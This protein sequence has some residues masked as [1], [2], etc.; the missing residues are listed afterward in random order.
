MAA[1]EQHCVEPDQ[2]ETLRI[3]NPPIRAEMR[4]PARQS[5]I[6]GGLIRVSAITDVVI[7]GYRGY[8]NAKASHQLSGMRQV[9]FD[10]R[11]IHRHV[12]GMD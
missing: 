7:A 8:A 6:I 5:L 1:G 3:F 10:I 11:A 2:A 9:F 12:A 4:P